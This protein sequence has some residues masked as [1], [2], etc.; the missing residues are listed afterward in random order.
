MIV[1]DESD[2]EESTGAVMAGF[3]PVKARHTIIASDDDGSG[4]DQSEDSGHNRNYGNGFVCDA[5]EVEGADH[6]EEEE[7]EFDYDVDGDN[8]DDFLVDDA[9]EV[10]EVDDVDPNENPDSLLELQQSLQSTQTSG[11]V[12]DF[13]TLDIT[14]F[15]QA[16][17]ANVTRIIGKTTQQLVEMDK[18]VKNRLL[19]ETVWPLLFHQWLKH[20]FVW[21]RK[22][23]GAYRF[24]SVPLAINTFSDENFGG[25]TFVMKNPMCDYATTNAFEGK[26][27]PPGSE[28]GL[29]PEEIIMNH[30]IESLL[31]ATQ[32][33]GI[34]AKDASDEDIILPNLS[35]DN[36]ITV[37]KNSLCRDGKFLK[38]APYDQ[39]WEKS[40]IKMPPHCLGLGST[41]IG[42]ASLESSSLARQKQCN[43]LFT[44]LKL[45]S[46]GTTP[47]THRKPSTKSAIVFGKSVGNDAF[48]IPGG[49]HRD[50]EFRGIVDPH[51]LDAVEA[52]M[53]KLIYRASSIPVI[54]EDEAE[55]TDAMYE[56]V[57][58]LW[59]FARPVFRLII[60]QVV[61]VLVK[62]SS[63][64]NLIIECENEINPE[65]FPEDCAVYICFVLGLMSKIA[66]PPSG[67]VQSLLFLV[68]GVP[69]SSKSTFTDFMSTA[70]GGLK[71]PDSSSNIR[72]NEYIYDDLKQFQK[73]RKHMASFKVQPDAFAKKTGL[74][75]T[76]ALPELGESTNKNGLI[77]IVANK[78]HEKVMSTYA[79]PSNWVRCANA[80][81]TNLLSSEK[82]DNENS[83][84]VDPG[85]RRYDLIMVPVKVKDKKEKQITLTQFTD[86]VAGNTALDGIDSR[87]TTWDKNDLDEREIIFSTVVLAALCE[88]LD[89]TDNFVTNMW[90][91]SESFSRMAGEIGALKTTKTED[92]LTA[93][94]QI[95]ALKADA[96]GLDSEAMLSTHSKSAEVPDHP[97]ILQTIVFPEDTIDDLAE[98]VKR[99]AQTG[100]LMGATAVNGDILRGVLAPSKQVKR[101]AC[102][103]CGLCLF[104]KRMNV[105]WP[106]VREND[107]GSCTETNG[108][109]DFHQLLIKR[110]P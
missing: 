89:G 105:L 70:F 54:T 48:N 84:A 107:F 11:F 101:I 59:R 102:K 110:L 36:C 41:V 79:P 8:W 109:H 85:S 82:S 5:A 10:H 96:L 13:S 28:S 45:N 68:V 88:N 22:L 7:G 69:G 87:D 17:L 80:L 61:N 92:V 6:S 97:G 31:R 91:G 25:T 51:F 16:L 74:A 21:L 108:R 34:M 2:S 29:P 33:G 76:D 30:A 50:S 12:T 77:H 19:K 20:G 60:T 37:L 66:T 75:H 72:E 103:A 95:F 38:Y 73:G 106:Y 98:Q 67:N 71:V 44:N 78:K 58:L 42:R 40:G 1:S 18:K 4:T 26:V 94:K 100:G 99:I 93:L 15:V 39:Q 3:R 14:S 104:D 52:D 62:T 86:A 46:D 24:E 49:P 23:H 90:N 43:K 53:K 27:L 56:I 65:Q 47:I 55:R 57:R 81:P 35:P 63:V 64:L 9:D 83:S 32:S